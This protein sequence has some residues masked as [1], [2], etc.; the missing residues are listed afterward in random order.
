MKAFHIINF[1]LIILLLAGICIA[2]EMVVSNSL[3]DIQNRSFKIER[4]IDDYESLKNTEIVLAIDNLEDKWREEE[5]NLCFMVNHKNI[6]EIGQEIAKIK[7][8][9]ASDDI[10]G[11][12]VSLYS[13]KFYCHSYLHFMGANLHN[14]L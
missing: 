8:Y 11:A 4:L 12:R 5:S 7:E 6:Q 14:V 10:D 2:E 9:V 3:K 13:I 1:V